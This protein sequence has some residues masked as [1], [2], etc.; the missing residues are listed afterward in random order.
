MGL[1]FCLLV[2]YSFWI[3]NWL[4]KNQIFTYETLLEIGSNYIH[5]HNDVP[6]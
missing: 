1:M 6:S 3:G 4:K 2:V 5:P